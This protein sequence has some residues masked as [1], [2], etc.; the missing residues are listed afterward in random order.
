[1]WW[2]GQSPAGRFLV[3]IVSV[4]AVAVAQAVA[5]SPRGLSRWTWPLALAG[6]GLAVYAVADPGR[7]LLLNRGDRAT[8]LWEA[9]S[10]GGVELE[11]YLPSLVRGAPDDWRVAAVWVAAIAVL[12]A[13]DRF[14]AQERVDRLF[15][16]LVLPLVV[17]LLVSIA[18]DGWARPRGSDLGRVPQASAAS[19][20]VALSWRSPRGAER[21]A[22]RNERA[23]RIPI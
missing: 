19:R 5:T 7:L 13:L 1:M 10:A 14:A 8:R 18:I 4:L 23:R 12:L 3:P 6:Y 2:G 22:P 9:L 16:S 20:T 11:R 15:D 17:L 21:G